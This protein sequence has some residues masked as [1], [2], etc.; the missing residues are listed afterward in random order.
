MNFHPPASTFQCLGIQVCTTEFIQ[1]VLEMGPMLTVD[2]HW[3]SR[4]QASS[5]TSDTRNHIA[6][7]IGGGSFLKACLVLGRVLA[8]CT[9]FCS[10]ET[11]IT[12]HLP[13]FETNASGLCILGSVC[14]AHYPLLLENLSLPLRE[15][16]LSNRPCW[17]WRQLLH[18]HPR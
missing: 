10:G 7:H 3:L 5:L 1:T 16:L 8:Y 11:I 9:L 4:C 14:P 17:S 13:S 18:C 2:Q 12:I 6:K 15:L